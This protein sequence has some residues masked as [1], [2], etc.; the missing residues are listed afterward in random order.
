M[1][2]S[3][4]S[5]R[6]RLL[7]ALRNGQSFT[8]SQIQTKFGYNSPNGAY[9]ALSVLRA[10]GYTIRSKLNRNQVNSYSLA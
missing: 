3:P 7:V 5:K 2:A 8:A 4:L 9:S 10:E 1:A 6:D